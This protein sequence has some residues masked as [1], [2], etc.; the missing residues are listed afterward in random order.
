M[1]RMVT[2][3]DHVAQIISQLVAVAFHILYLYM[4]SSSTSGTSAYNS[5][6]KRKSDEAAQCP[7]T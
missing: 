7:E 1:T 2:S 6:T 4:F 3:L 5:G